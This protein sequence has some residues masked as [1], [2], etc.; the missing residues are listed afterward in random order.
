[1][2]DSAPERNQYVI[3]LSLATLVFGFGFYKVLR[4]RA[5]QKSR[6]GRAGVVMLGVLLGVMVLLNAVPWRTLNRRNFPRIDSAGAHCYITGRSGD[7]Y[8]VLC[9]GSD[10]PRN[11]V[12]R[13]DDPR[14]H[15]TGDS[16]NVFKGVPFRFVQ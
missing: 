5:R 7:E 13:A 16:E 3:Q 6:E 14:W 15:V 9:P 11:R 2:T 1:M 4:M 10:P 12:V 8:M